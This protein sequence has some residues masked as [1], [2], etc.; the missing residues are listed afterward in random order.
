[1]RWEWESESAKW[2][3]EEGEEGVKVGEGGVDQWEVQHTPSFWS[4]LQRQ[5]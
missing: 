4:W 5:L 1:M 2:R 3:W